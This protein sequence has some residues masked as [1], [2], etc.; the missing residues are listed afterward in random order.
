MQGDTVM[1]IV[2]SALLALSVLAGSV[3]P[4]SAYNRKEDPGL[5]LP[6]SDV[7][8]LGLPT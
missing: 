2:V 5:P 4:A 3:G 7:Y 1:K 6:N 8:T